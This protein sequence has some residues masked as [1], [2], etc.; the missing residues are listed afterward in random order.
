MGGE[1]LRRND[2]WNNEICVVERKIISTRDGSH[3]LSIPELQVT[4]H[5]IHG[6]E[7]ESQHVFLRAGMDCALAETTV[8]PL[9]ILEMGL[10]TGLN[11]LLTMERAIQ[12]QRSVVYTAVEKYPLLPAEAMLLNYCDHPQRHFLRP[13][14]SELHHC[15]WNTR[16][17]LHPLFSVEK[18][19][20]DLID[21]PLPAEPYH[22]IYFDAFAPSAQPELWTM[23]VFYRL[24]QS[25]EPGAILTTYC[26]KGEVR[27][28]MEAAGWKIEKIPGPPGKREM[29]RARK[30]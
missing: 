19:N 9:R 4:Y 10:G 7:Q 14:Y 12:Q 18:W 16:T 27:R 24:A 25:C 22:L 26:S 20:I 3:S 28:N 21:L 2:G 8:S 13:L 30:T 6:A 29:V 23:A 11:A 5:S 15:D 17:V 1:K